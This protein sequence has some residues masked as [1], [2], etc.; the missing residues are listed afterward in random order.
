MKGVSGLCHR[1][2]SGL[3]HPRILVTAVAM[4]VAGVVVGLKCCGGGEISSHP[5]TAQAQLNSNS[6]A[7]TKGSPKHQTR[8]VPN[9]NNN[10]QQR[11]EAYQFTRTSSSNPNTTF[12]LTSRLFTSRLLTSR[13]THCGLLVIKTNLNGFNSIRQN[14][15]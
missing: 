13:H 14:L 5:S 12:T 15:S 10:G 7:T 4:V 8:P 11:D 2:H 6:T 1:R 9:S 3:Y